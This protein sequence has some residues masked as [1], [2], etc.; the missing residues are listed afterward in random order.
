LANG[1]IGPAAHDVA[2]PGRARPWVADY[3]GRAI[4][5]LTPDGRRIA[6][7]FAGDFQTPVALAVDAASSQVWVCDQYGGRL[8]RVSQGFSAEEIGAVVQPVAVA[9]EHVTR[10]VWVADL[11][12][13]ALQ[14]FDINN[15]STP[16]VDARG[17]ATPLSVAVDAVD[18]SA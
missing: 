9:I 3:T 17:L 15:P 4:D 16:A 2:T 7:T 13:G 12:L 5:L 10:R 18:G 1:A 6:S 8:W 11:S 14:S